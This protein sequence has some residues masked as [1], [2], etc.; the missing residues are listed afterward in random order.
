MCH[1]YRRD[2]M[3]VMRKVVLDAVNWNVLYLQDSYCSTFACF[4][5]AQ[6]N[7]PSE[8]GTNVNW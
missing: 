8:F 5:I 6:C 7:S 4:Y 1:A 3:S 2:S